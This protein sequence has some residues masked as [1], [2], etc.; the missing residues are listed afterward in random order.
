M[1]KR[2]LNLLLLIS[3]FVASPAFAVDYYVC[4]NA[5]DGNAG[6]GSGWSTGVDTTADSQGLSK[7]KP[8]KTIS[9]AMAS[10]SLV[11]AGDTVTV[12]DG[13]YTGSGNNTLEI[14][15]S[16]SSG[17]HIV[18][19]AENK[20]QASIDSEYSN[21]YYGVWVPDA[22]HHVTINGFVIERSYFT[23]MRVEGPN[24]TVSDCTFRDIGQQEHD[25]QG[26]YS[27]IL[28]NTGANDL[29]ITRCL[30]YAIGRL[31]PATT[32]AATEAS[33]T[34]GEGNA[35][36]NHDHAIYHHGGSDMVI[37][38][39]ICYS[40]YSGWAIQVYSYANF[41]G[42]HVVHNTFVVLN[43]G[44]D[45]APLFS[46][47]GFNYSNVLVA[48]NVSYVDDSTGI[49]V[50]WPNAYTN[51]D[52]Y[53]NVTNATNSVN[54]GVCADSDF[55][56]SGNV[57]SATLTFEDYANNDFRPIATDDCVGAG[58]ATYTT[59][60]YGTDVDYNG[61][62]RDDSPPT[63][64]AYDFGGG[65]AS[66]PP[67]PPPGRLTITPTDMKGTGRSDATPL[68]RIQ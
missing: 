27:G 54:V 3:L 26:G 4:D 61:D 41:S 53:N 65:A 1:L 42:L 62:T 43:P 8:W 37:S 33:C 5:T 18:L 59:A 57:A 11:S 50:S 68:G 55:D 45:G 20:R 51:V 10:G 31:N 58:D 34:S 56:C 49:Y 67:V 63:A 12:A 6:D 22:Y 36:W 64:G 40:I 15:R 24:I 17:N 47:A 39:N 38:N 7:A 35:C 14:R 25:G 9:Y 32:P 30:F 46:S 66:V 44:R 21:V 13:T 23:G 29:L 28:T 2:S 52:I 60:A 16:G 19:Q 48:N